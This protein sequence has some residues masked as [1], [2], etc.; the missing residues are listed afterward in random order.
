MKVAII[1]L[2]LIGGSWGLALRRW[3]KS[4]EGKSIKLEIVG[5]D[6][7]ATQRSEAEKQ[8][9]CDRTT[10]T[11]MEAVQGA[12]V[13]IIATPPAAVRETFE[14]IADHLVNGAIITDT[15][16][17]KRQ[18]LRWAKELLPTTVSF[19]GGH[20]MAGKTSSLEG[21]TA[22][23]FKNCIYCLVPAPTAR[24]EAIE[25][26]ARLV[27]IIGAKSHFIDPDEHDSYVA[28]I[29]HLPFLMSAALTN[30]TSESEGWREISK[31]TA[32]GY[33]DATRLSGGSV[34]MHLDICRTNSDAIIGWL[35]RYQRNL[36]ELRTMLENAGMI[37][38]RGR[39][40]SLESTNSVP[41]QEYL[42]RARLARERWEEEKA[43]QPERDEMA[44]VVNMPSKRE[45][46]AEYTRM[47]TGGFFG[48][49]RSNDNGSNEQ[50]RKK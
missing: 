5:F 13:I 49:R 38:E 31:L 22:D 34:P 42:E 46:Q 20:P 26:V 14:D 32:G 12:D 30:L 2:G 11:P 16:S 29:S 25:A 7:K 45:L 1:G 9:V 37:D 10:A 21:A 47:F 4:E 23:L 40:R 19:I 41:L 3:G 36:S 18:V 33:Q 44:E 39:S 28:A 27:E 17:T 8:G 43:R 6:V 24:E 15:A 35:D 50:P 48:K